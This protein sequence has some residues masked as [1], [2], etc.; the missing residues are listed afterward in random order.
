[1][2]KGDRLWYWGRHLLTPHSTG[3]V[4]QQRV[5]AYAELQVTCSGRELVSAF[6]VWTRRCAADATGCR[7]TTA[8]GCRRRLGRGEK[9]HGQRQQ[10]Q[11][12]NAT[13]YLGALQRE[14]ANCGVGCLD[15]N[16]VTIKHQQRQDGGAAVVCCSLTVT[17][18]PW[19]DARSRRNR[20]QRRRGGFRDFNRYRR[21]GMQ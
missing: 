8:R 18:S 14:C 16:A 21:A 15:P 4:R 20:L 1:M 2:S 5:R 3:R 12:R 13:T 9:K 10:Q 17:S 19:N 6:D 11:R 7:T